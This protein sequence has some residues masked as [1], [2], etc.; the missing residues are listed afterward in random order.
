VVAHDEEAQLP[1]C[2]TSLA[3]ADEVMVVLD[4]CTDRSR[5]IALAAGA[6][7]LE[8][9]WPVEGDRRNAGFAAC[10]GD[11]ILEVDADER[12]PEALADEIRETV[13][14]SSAD[15]HLVPVDNY[16]GTRLVRYGWGAS[17]GRS[18]H[19]AL[20][21]KGVK[22]WGRQR[23]HPSLTFTPGAR[24]GA[25]LEVPLVHYG[26]SS[27]ADLISRLNSYSDRRAAD[28]RDSGELGAA[29]PNYRRIVSRFWRCFVTRK[30]YKE[31][32]IG[33]LIA[34]CG[35]LYPLLSHLKATYDLSDDT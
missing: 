27:I 10:T 21:R 25:W 14:D 28:L 11:W 5:E 4:R 35:A 13:L 24:A 31:G 15:Y 12:V 23:V 34:V 18:A 2:L 32:G 19:P 7:I 29:L 9:A 20:S 8:G 26:F 22:T 3:F 30:G 33:F 6:R 17:F 16:V 1:A